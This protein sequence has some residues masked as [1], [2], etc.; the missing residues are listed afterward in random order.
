MIWLFLSAALAGKYDG[1][2]A[3]VVATRTLPNTTP[4]AVYAAL[5]TPAALMALYPTDCAVWGIPLAGDVPGAAGIVSYHAAGMHRKLHVT[6]KTAD[7]DKPRV[8]LDHAGNK[9]FV[10]RFDLAAADTATTV[11]M[12]NFLNAPPSPFKGYYFT[13]VK[14]A[15]DGCHARVLEALEKTA[16][17]P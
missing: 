15:W 1:V 16:A 17:A 6:W 9:G 14:P 4:A 3:N 12:T 13:R 10:T 2:D 5:S 11:T 7:A 8:E